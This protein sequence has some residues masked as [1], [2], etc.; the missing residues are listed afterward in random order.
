MEWNPT[1]YRFFFVL[2]MKIWKKNHR[3]SNYHVCPKGWKHTKQYFFFLYLLQIFGSR[4]YSSDSNWNSDSLGYWP[5]KSP[6]PHHFSKKLIIYRTCALRDNTCKV[7]ENVSICLNRSLYLS[8]KINKLKK[9]ILVLTNACF[10]KSYSFNHKKHKIIP[11][12][13]NINGCVW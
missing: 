4:R 3:K 10:Y 12:K 5:M 11:T 2:L 1:I 6:P 13:E 7:N 9:Y 8:K